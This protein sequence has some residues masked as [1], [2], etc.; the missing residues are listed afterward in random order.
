MLPP[1]CRRVES[2]VLYFCKVSQPTASNLSP[3]ALA[4]LQSSVCGFFCDVAASYDQKLIQNTLNTVKNNN[5]LDY[6]QTIWDKAIKKNGH[7]NA[8]NPHFGVINK[9]HWLLVRAWEIETR[10]N[11]PHHRQFTPD[12]SSGHNLPQ[13]RNGFTMPNQYS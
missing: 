4:L 8:S 2:S 5:T 6:L 3:A 11:V 7:P 12:T 1:E 10:V 9:K 13:N